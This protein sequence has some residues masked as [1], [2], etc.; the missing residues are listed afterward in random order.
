MNPAYMVAIVLS[1][2][3]AGQRR[4]IQEEA[5]QYLCLIYED[6]KAWQKLPPAESAEDHAASSWPTPSR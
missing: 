3:Q 6:E 4:A 2:A 5:M 1:A